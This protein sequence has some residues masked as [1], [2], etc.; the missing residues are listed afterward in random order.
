VFA[1][2]VLVECSG[3]FE[4]MV[5]VR[6]HEGPFSRVDAEVDGEG[7]AIGKGLVAVRAHVGPFSRVDA[8]VR[9]KV[10]ALRKL[11]WAGGAG[12]GLLPSVGTNVFAPVLIEIWLI[13]QTNNTEIKTVPGEWSSKK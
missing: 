5:A 1:T 8:E 13:N 12:E 3:P 9:G 11:L 2:H 10:A 6:A 4:I 7:A